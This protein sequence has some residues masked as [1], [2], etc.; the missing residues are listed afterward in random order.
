[1]SHDSSFTGGELAFPADGV[2]L[3]TIDRPPVNALGW[4]TYDGLSAALGTVARSSA[5]RALVLT[6]TGTRAFSAGSDIRE[7]QTPGDYERIAASSAQF[8]AALA[9]VPIPVVG[10]L[11]GPAVGGGAMIASECDV[12]IAVP[13]A[14]FSIPELSLGVPGSGSQSKRLA[15]MFKVSRML[16]L[17]EKMTVE[18]AVS[19]GTVASVVSPDALV[20]TA[21]ELASR[22]AALE[23]DAVRAAR[24]IFRGRETG[25]AQAG[26]AAELAAAVPIVS[27]R[28]ERD[29]RG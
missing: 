17:G 11:N 4:E 13:D 25:W 20:S 8:F 3:L 6:A 15:P 9:G 22:I 5:V 18:E 21:V 27:A 10:A 28:L 16:L 24:A 26:Y 12:L 19:Y 1:M 14:D 7:F 23:P 29:G 2:A